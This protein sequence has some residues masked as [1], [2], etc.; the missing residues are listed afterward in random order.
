M[1]DPEKI[2]DYRF[3]TKP[4]TGA[5]DR[6]PFNLYELLGA[7]DDFKAVKTQLQVVMERLDVN[8]LSTPICHPEIAG[9]GIEYC[10]G[11]GKKDFRKTRTRHEGQLPMNDFHA[12]LRQSFDA[13]QTGSLRKEVSNNARGR[14][15]ILK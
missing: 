12:M 4:I 14:P 8:V 11:I 3:A 10:W 5:D 1:V 13:S 6:N 7:C 2:K 15:G 9:E